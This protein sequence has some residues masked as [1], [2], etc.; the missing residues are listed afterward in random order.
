MIFVLPL[1]VLILLSTLTLMLIKMSH[2]CAGGVDVAS[3]DVAGGDDDVDGDGKDV[4]DSCSVLL[5]PQRLPVLQPPS[6]LG[7]NTTGLANVNSDKINQ[8]RTTEETELN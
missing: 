8:L 1:S 3:G 5:R 6:Q 2:C 7:A 4:D